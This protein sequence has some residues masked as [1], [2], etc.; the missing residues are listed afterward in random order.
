MRRAAAVVAA[1]MGLL[2]VQASIDEVGAGRL[3]EVRAP[4]FQLL[5]E[6]APLLLH[7]TDRQGPER[8]ST[9]P[10]ADAAMLVCGR[11][12]FT[13]RKRHVQR[14]DTGRQRFHLLLSVCG[15]PWPG[16]AEGAACVHAGARPSPSMA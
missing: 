16:A 6:S 1:L 2:L 15:K 5:Y 3:Q 8:H 4:S 10:P 12:H 7:S 13:V 14:T 11:G 9:P